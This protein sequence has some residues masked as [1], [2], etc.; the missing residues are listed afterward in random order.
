MICK[1]C[2][3]NETENTSGICDECC[4][5]PQELSR[6][7]FLGRVAIM[8]LKSKIKSPEFARV[9]LKLRDKP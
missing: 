9:L 5:Y 4:S 6:D 1:I 8:F 7:Y 2:H 3:L